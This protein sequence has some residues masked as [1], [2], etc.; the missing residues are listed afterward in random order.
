MNINSAARLEREKRGSEFSILSL[1]GNLSAQ[2]SIENTPENSYLRDLERLMPG[3]MHNSAYP[4]IPL[5][6]LAD[7]TARPD[8]I[9][10]GRRDMTVAGV[11]GSNYLVG[12]ANSQVSEMLTPYSV[13]AQAGITQIHGLR[14]N[15]LIP[16]ETAL[17]TSYWIADENTD[18]TESQPSLGV[19]SA[20]P[21]MASVLL[22][23]TEQFRRQ[24]NAEDYLRSA[25]L[26]SIGRLID[27][28]V[29]AGTG[30]SG[31][32]LGLIHAIGAQ[33]QSGT[34][35]GMAGL[36]AMIQNA[37]ENGAQ[38]VGFIA[39]PVAEA[40]L[41]AREAA[42]GNG[43]C[44]SGDTLAG[45]PAYATVLAPAST[46]ISGPWPAISLLTW[47]DLT[48]QVTHANFASGLLAMRIMLG[49]DVVVTNAAAFTVSSSV[50]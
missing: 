34:S 49:V 42:S 22:H 29:I 13:T 1:V 21:K 47:G 4:K 40:V 12:T 11:S 16:R 46:V 24:G 25:L 10:R 50:T 18:I 8:E 14:D 28:A 35:L 41:R 9:A 19:M 39:D 27:Q 45:V 37:R 3:Y 33:T 5:E 17:P 15:V 48:V 30:N 44:W 32:P 2:R 38:S 36:V 7:S 20:T 6:L 43:F 26:R 23:M 31:Q